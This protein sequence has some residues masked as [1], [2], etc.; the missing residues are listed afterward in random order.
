MKILIAD[1]EALVRR[2]IRLFLVN[3]GVLTEDISEA[4]NGLFMLDALQT[5]HYDLALVDIRMPAMDGLKAIRQAQTVSPCTK[6]YILSGFDDF[7]YAQ[8]AIRL[9]VCD[10]ILKPIKPVQI[11]ELLEK[12]ISDIEQQKA[13]L[14]KDLTVYTTAL[15]TFTD[16]PIGFPITCHPVLITN[17][18]Y[19][20]FLSTSELLA[21]DNDKIMVVPYK[22][23]NGTFLFLFETPEYPGYYKNYL[24]ELIHHCAGRHTIIEGRELQNNL[25]WKEEYE[26]IISIKT[27]RPV[28]KPQTLYRSFQKPPQLPPLL[29]ELCVQC[30]KSLQALTG[31]DYGKFTLS[32][33]FLIKHLPSAVEAYP[34]AAKNMLQF[35]KNAYKLREC[36]VQTLQNQLMFLSAT[37]MQPSSKD[38]VHDELLSYVQQHYKEDL[39]L[40]GLSSIFGLSPNY[41]STIFK[42]KAGC[43]FVNYLTGLRMKEGKRLLLE[44]RM[45]IREIGISVGYNNTSFFIRS[46]KKAEGITPTEYRKSMVQQ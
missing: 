22:E 27:G 23:K 19:G 25:I 38:S 9:G 26:R 5:G 37:V 7:K 35:L 46:F 17:D 4:S 39:S 24:A 29:V 2:S 10:Y 20:E 42:Q 32:C 45:T 11:E 14:L 40:S 8:E 13:L 41:I 1:D 3:L 34:A 44:T 30:N 43:N 16:A 18:I 28:F 21:K 36:S 15:F 33:G 12:T 6:Y 31:N